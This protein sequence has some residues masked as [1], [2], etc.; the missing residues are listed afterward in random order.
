[1]SVDLPRSPFLW[2]AALALWPLSVTAQDAGL[3]LTMPAPISGVKTR[4]ETA[5]AYALPIGPYADGRLPSRSF[6]GTLDQ[7]AWRKIGRSLEK[8]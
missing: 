3:N 6:E 1:M 5:A 8:V 7:R 2:A 4:T